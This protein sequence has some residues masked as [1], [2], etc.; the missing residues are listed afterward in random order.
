MKSSYCRRVRMLILLAIFWLAL[1]SCEQTTENTI[2]AASHRSTPP[3]A[4]PDP[5]RKDQP[6]LVLQYAQ[7]DRSLDVTFASRAPVFASSNE[8]GS[9]D[10]W[11]TRNWTLK[12]TVDTGTQVMSRNYNTKDIVLSPDGRSVAYMTGS[13]EVQIWATGSGKLIKRL[14]AP[15]GLPV[16]VKWSPDGRRIAAGSTDVVRIWDVASG[17]VIRTFPAT[18]DVAFSA[19]G[20]IFGA[21]GENNA[22]LFDI[23]SGRKICSFSDKAGVSGPIAISPGGQYVATG[24]EDPD[25]DPGPLPRD[26]DGNEFAPSEAYYSHELKVKI[27][28]ARTGSRLRMFS[29]HNNLGGGTQV[30]QF[31][32]DGRRLFSAGDGS[33]DLWNVSNAAHIRSFSTSGPG[34][35]SPDG[36]MVAVTEGSPAMFSVATGKKLIRLRAPPQPVISLAFSPDGRFLAAGD[37]GPGFTSLRLWGVENGRLSRAMQGPPPDL[38]SV[39]FVSSTEVFSNS[40]NGIYR[41]DPNTGKLRSKHKGP[42]DTSFMGLGN[43]WALLTPDGR[44]IVAESG[45]VFDKSFVVCDLETGKLITTIAAARAGSLGS[46]AFSPNGRYFAVHAWLG[47]GSNSVRIWDIDT[48]R[49]LSELDDIGEGAVIL[50]FSPDGK[51]IAGSL[52]SPVHMPEGKRVTDNKIVIWDTKSGMT[53]Q[54]L[55]LGKKPARVLTFSPDGRTLAAGIGAYI[56]LHNAESLHDT[57]SMCAGKSPVSALAF[58]TD[59]R[60]VAAGHEDGRVRLW[61]TEPRRLLITML[62]FSPADGQNVS[63]DW[64]AY[65]P[66]GRYDWSPGAASLLKWRY[67]GKMYP[68]EAFSRQLQRITTVW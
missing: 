68:A 60:F 53:K 57:G 54:R 50:V 32:P 48:G 37:Q 40:L 43:R 7:S 33:A 2:V 23:A 52:P 27:W 24:G 28:D 35:L 61:K 67:K 30:L 58:S 13:G 26:E 44:K 9:I 6:E 41:W 63:Q 8:D 4:H 10:I 36:R 20:K 55:I 1:T 45:E 56:H 29:G 12:R 5:P 17:K 3:V 18:G 22:F 38:H 59:G 51:T 14:P 16:S 66:D 65:T 21:A 11:D 19:D 34:A 46:A 49:K 25:W 64:I 42:K 31:T 62:G 47:P 15:V 39:G